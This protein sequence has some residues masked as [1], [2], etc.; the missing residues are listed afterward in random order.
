MLEALYRGDREQAEE[1]A[2]GRELD[3]FE[4]AALG[5]TD[6]VGELLRTHPELARAYARDGFT[7]LHLAAFFGAPGAA[8]A[9]LDYRAD[10]DAVARN[11]MRVT[12]LHSAAA[13]AERDIVRMLLD[14]GADPNARQEG[15][16][17]PIHAAAQNG[18][19]ELYELLRSR[20]ADEGA[21]L[22]DGRTVADLRP[23]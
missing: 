17:T 7:A 11:P 23:S 2:E 5:R 1:A 12:P 6:R 14:A 10:A 13:A 20:G 19:Y 9:L 22:D 15:G 4:A 18:D 8:R 3:V 21:A 16:F